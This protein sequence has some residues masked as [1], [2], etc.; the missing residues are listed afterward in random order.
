MGARLILRT[1]L[2]FMIL[3][4][5]L[6]LLRFH[7]FQTLYVISIQQEDIG[8]VLADASSALKTSVHTT[9]GSINLQGDSSVGTLNATLQQAVDI[10]EL[11]AM[12]ES[13]RFV[14]FLCDAKYFFGSVALVASLA[15]SKT[16]TSL[17]PLVI[18]V[19]ADTIKPFQRQVLE[20]LGA[21]VKIV[22]QPQELT[23][24]V[25][26]R[27]SS[28]SRR[29]QGVFAK[30]LVFRRDLVECDIVFYID[31][32]AL[33]RGDLIECMYDIIQ[34]FQSN[35]KLDI[36]A[37]GNRTYFNAGIMLARPRRTTYSYL[38]A[39]LRNGTCV[40][41]CT[42][43]DYKTMMRRK[44]NADQDIIIEYTERFPERFEPLKRKSRLNLRPMHQKVDVHK[45][46]SVVHYAGL[47]KPWQPWSAVPSIDFPVNGSTLRMLPDS[48]PEAIY[49]LKNRSK[50]WDL[51]DW[52][53]ELWRSQWNQAV[54]QLQASQQLSEQSRRFST[55]TGQI[56]AERRIGSQSS[57][58]N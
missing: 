19:G 56:H 37:V 6:G 8:Q 54:T 29:W 48:I 57:H 49:A 26:L 33:A 55:G 2:L 27:G 7:M 21:Q 28:V 39:M 9:T 52:S 23:D 3:V 41:N 42:E 17:S 38:I 50:T 14:L 53:L 51:A 47:P 12:R 43:S 5:I 11:T 20:A 25:E 45:N 46:C 24:A 31:V 34:R 10:R 18:V 32:D 35:P 30:M 1:F 13:T 44:I 16:P 22:K 4:S 58:Q 36:L 40:G 15:E